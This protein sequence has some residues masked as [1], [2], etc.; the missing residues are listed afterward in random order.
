MLIIINYLKKRLKHN[1]LTIVYVILH[2]GG[3]VILHIGGMSE[4]LR[5]QT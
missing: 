1:I 5:R 4:W 2:I 3:Y